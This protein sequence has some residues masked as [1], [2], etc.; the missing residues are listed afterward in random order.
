VKPTKAQRLAV[1]A[2]FDGRCAYCGIVL[3]A[4]WHVDHKDPVIRCD[5]KRSPGPLTADGRKAIHADRHNIENMFPACPGCNIDKGG[6]CVDGYR[7]WIVAHVRG[8]HR[9]SNFRSALRHG[10]IAETNNPVVF[11]FE[12]VANERGAQQEQPEQT[13]QGG[14]EAREGSLASEPQAATSAVRVA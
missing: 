1:H 10:L 8:L 12:R 3:G 4:R 6:F 14:R 5:P 13:P 9:Q 2:M 7:E 11:Y